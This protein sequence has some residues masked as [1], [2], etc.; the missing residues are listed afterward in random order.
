VIAR[1][2]ER[3]SLREIARRVGKS[4]EWVRRTMLA[5]ELYYFGRPR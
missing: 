3:K 5:H 2:S 1:W 4:H